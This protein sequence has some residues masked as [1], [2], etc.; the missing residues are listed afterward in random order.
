MGGRE[1]RLLGVIFVQISA[2]GL[3]LVS[4][5]EGCVLHLYNCPAGHCSIGVG[6]LVHKGPV[7]GDP[8]EEPFKDGIT[9][10]QAEELLV[11]DVQVAAEAVNRLVTAE[12]TQAEFDALVDFAFNVG[13]GALAGSTLLRDLKR[14]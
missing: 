10:A 13:V 11:K 6:H 8:S 2:A 12:I 1:S 7:C 3:A 4:R 5:F 9:Q 14:R